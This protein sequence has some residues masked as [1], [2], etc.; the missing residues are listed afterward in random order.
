MGPAFS[1]G[2]LSRGFISRGF[3]S[4]GS[5]SRGFVSCDKNE[6]MKLMRHIERVVY[7]ISILQDLHFSNFSRLRIL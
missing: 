1:R 5:S 7:S 4:R 2:F 6:R 3:V